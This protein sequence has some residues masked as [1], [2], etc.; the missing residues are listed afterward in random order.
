M[1]RLQAL[2]R[3]GCGAQRSIYVALNYSTFVWHNVE[4]RARRGGDEV[5][6]PGTDFNEK[7]NVRIRWLLITDTKQA[8]SWIDVSLCFPVNNICLLNFCCTM[9]V[10]TIKKREQQQSSDLCCD[11]SG[12]GWGVS[13]AAV[14]PQRSCRDQKHSQWD[15]TCFF[16]LH[17]LNK[18]IHHGDAEILKCHVSSDNP[19]LSFLEQQLTITMIIDSSVHSVFDWSILQN[20]FSI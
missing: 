16:S 10:N 7:T 19:L 9:W 2:K 12:R 11:W 17:P 20:S 13:T 8:A 14:F 1:I 6:N 4:M 5:E 3:E 18:I 15:T